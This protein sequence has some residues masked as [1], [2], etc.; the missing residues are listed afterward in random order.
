M[1]KGLENP[2]ATYYPQYS[3]LLDS[4]STVKSVVLISD[5][6]DSE[7]IILDLFT[8]FFDIAKPEGSKNVEYHMSDILIQLIDG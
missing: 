2:K 4:L 3:Y 1:L 7:H 5:I 6:P 8:S